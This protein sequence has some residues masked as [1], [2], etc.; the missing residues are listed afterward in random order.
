MNNYQR[1]DCNQRAFKRRKLSQQ[2]SQPT[3][4]VFN[5]QQPTR[6]TIDNILASGSY[7]QLIQNI[8]S[9]PTNEFS[10]SELLAIITKLSQPVHEFPKD[11]SYIS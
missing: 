5:F 3:V 7:E 2:V 8:V 6:P 11:C 10:K 4:T 1:H 9:H